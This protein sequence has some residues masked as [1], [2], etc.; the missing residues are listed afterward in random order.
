DT[1]ALFS[2]MNHADIALGTWYPM[3]GMG[4]LV[5]GLHRIAVEQGVR[6]H[7]NVTV[8][9][10]QVKNGRSTGVETA[11]GFFPAEVVVAT[12]DYHHVEQHLLAEEYRSYSA[13]YWD[14]R[15]LAPA[16]LL[17][18]VGIDRRLP[19]L[20][21]HTL[22]FDASL[23]EHSADIYTKQGWPRDPLF[24][25]SCTSRTDPG[26]APEGMEN[27]VVLIPIAS[28]AEDT[29]E[30]R[31]HYFEVV[32]D[33]LARYLGFDLRPHVRVRRDHCIKDMER[34]HHAYKGN[35]YGLANTLTQ[36][37]PLRPR[38][39]SRKVKGLYFAGQLSIP[40]PGVPPA[41]ISGQVVADL[42]RSEQRP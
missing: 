15:K 29:T 16:T 25:V 27:V 6:F 34:E 11:V 35:A 21:H 23:D 37:G 2:L 32:M 36:T 7:N 41:L 9:R 33:R 18:F 28:G 10:I 38:V 12:A 1:P 24:Y 4:S 42:I 14:D 40:G 39:K 22:F 5:E 17:F 13:S 8:T 19:G 31:E 3:G 26:T 20:L 30:L